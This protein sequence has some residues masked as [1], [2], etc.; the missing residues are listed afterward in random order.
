MENVYRVVLEF[1]KNHANVGK[2]GVL[3]SSFGGYLCLRTVTYNA[4][5]ITA[6]VSKGGSYFPLRNY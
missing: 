5:L 3:G 1:L 4:D 6:C 2:I